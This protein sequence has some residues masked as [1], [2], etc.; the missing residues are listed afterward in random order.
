MHYVLVPAAYEETFSG[1]SGTLGVV[2]GTPAGAT[3]VNIDA[4]GGSAGAGGAKFNVGDIVHFLDPDGQEYEVTGISTDT[5][6]I[7]QKDDP[8][9]KG[10]K[11]ALTDATNVRRR[12]RFYDLFDS[13]PGTSTFAT[14]K[15][16]G[17]D[18]LHIVVYDRTGDISGF[19]A[20]TSVKEHFQF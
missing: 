20:D 14:G 7:R 11:T 18:E 3:T 6:T 8:N 5:L 9:G 19:R 12:F 13:A 2:D 17:L 10:L 4:G 16:V 1:N 15:G